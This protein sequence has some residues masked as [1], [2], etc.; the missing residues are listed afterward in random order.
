MSLKSEDVRA[1]AHLA[2]VQLDEQDIPRYAQELSA[3]LDLVEKLNAADTDAVLP[4]AHPQDVSQRLR[5]DEV[6]EAD[7]RERFQG[8]APQ[9]EDGL[10]IVPPVLEQN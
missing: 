4:M 3:I 7:Q 5:K 10:Y 8:I 6:S 2:R 1:V 9:V